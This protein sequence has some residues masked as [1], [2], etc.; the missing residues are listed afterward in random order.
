[1]LSFNSFAQK[2]EK[3][4][5][6]YYYY[7]NQD[8]DFMAYL[9]AKREFENKKSDFKLPT[10][11]EAIKELESSEAKIFKNE[12][13]YAEFLSKYGMKN[14]GEYAEIWFNQMLTLK[15]FIKKNPEFYKLSPKERQSIIDKWY[16]TE[17]V[18]Q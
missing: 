1:M 4:I 11:K 12:R 18:K 2:V 17:K 16:Y 13:T 5:K 3:D 6:Y 7:L 15:T 8:Q 9:K 14:A 10:S